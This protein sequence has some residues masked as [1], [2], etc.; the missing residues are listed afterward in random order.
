MSNAKPRR[1]IL[2]PAGSIEQLVAAVNNGCDSVYLGLDS[3]NARMKA[4]N[5]TVENIG[6]WIDYCHLFGVKVYVAINTSVKNNEFAKAVELLETVYLNNADGVIVTDLALMKI[7]ARLPKPFDVVASTQLNA[8]D[9]FGAEFLQECGATTVVCAR[10][11]SLDEIRDVASTGVNVE[12]F[13]HG[14]TCVCQSGQCLFSA[15]VGGNSGNRGLCAQPCRKLYSSNNGQSRGYLLSA[16]D[17]CGLDTASQ[18]N[19]IGVG[20]YKI[21]GRNRRAEYA[22]ITSRV[23][24][25]LFDNEFKYDKCD[26]DDL[27]EMYNRSMSSLSYLD[28]DNNDIIAPNV[29]NHIGVK[30]GELKGRAFVAEKEIAKGD[31]LK[32][33][34]GNK[35]ICGGVAQSNGM[36]SICAD[37]G[38]VVR[39]G[40]QVRRTTS[41][42]LCE[43]VQ[44]A[45]RLL[46]VSIEFTA[47]PD[48]YAEIKA[49]YNDIQIEFKSEFTVQK[50]LKIPTTEQEIV[51][52]LRKTG[53]SHYTITD[54]IVEK[55]DIFLAKSQINALRRQL[56]EILDKAIVES[57]D[58]Q[59]SNRKNA[60]D[61]I[62]D[63]KND[64]NN[65]K[66]ANKSTTTN[67]LAVTCYTKEQLQQAQG[68]CQYL[69]YKPQ[70]INAQTITD[71]R[72]YNA[73]VDLPAFSD[74]KYLYELMSKSSV[75]IVCHNVGHVEL[76]RKLNLLYIAGSG[77]NIYN[78]FIAEKFS[79]A[80]TFVYS[81]ELTLSEIAEFTNQTGLVFVDGN[82]TLMKLVHC[83]YKLNYKC[84]CSTCQAGKELTYTDELGNFFNIIRRKDGR[85][86][87]ELQNGKKLSVISKLKNGG[88][89]LIDYNAQI[90]NH[91]L[92]LNKGIDDGYTETETYTK[93]RLFSKVN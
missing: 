91:Y 84:N 81:L 88:R 32:V 47:Y 10:E 24:R 53:N 78:D 44:N 85:C 46:P 41:V 72:E 89:F 1:E 65:T 70:F 9:S 74:N 22:G 83:P 12:C 62:A 40:M 64:L 57:Y 3:F 29:Q 27:A 80:K 25:H 90:I 59:F 30:V 76:A 67:A 48:C 7:A 50:A 87:F 15:M 45:K 43:E 86:T 31:G 52:Q 61:I 93:G 19:D 69:I 11:S 18:L 2:A 13:I 17:L 14:A 42:K 39:D 82:I 75:G 60:D 16:R 35:E 79:D 58:E 56:F 26:L 5:F 33:F 38:G 36:G 21:E 6:Q 37:F 23:Y 49:R 66:T 73:F 34:D 63:I 4:P 55:G 51:E 68:T 71:A 54:I 77:L 92:S 20:T 8:H 28:G